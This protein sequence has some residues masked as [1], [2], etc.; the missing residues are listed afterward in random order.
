MRV[1]GALGGGGQAEP[2]RGDRADRPPGRRSGRAGGGTRR[3]R[4]G[5]T[6][7]PAGPCSGRP[8]RRSSPSAAGC[9]SS[10]RRAGRPR[11]RSSGVSSSY[12]WFIRSIVGV[13]TRVGRSAC[14]MA[15]LAR[16]VLPVPVGRTTTPRP[17]AFHQAF[18]PFGLVRERLLGDPDR[19][20]RRLRLVGAGVVD[21]GDLP[22]AKVLHDRPVPDRLGAVQAG[23][24][25]ELDARQAAVVALRQ[26]L[27]E[28]RPLVEDEPQ[29][30][31]G[32]R[33]RSE[34]PA[35]SSRPRSRTESITLYP[36]LSCPGEDH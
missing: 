23:P 2:E 24:R 9:R 33:S 22:V 25:V 27:D 13:M 15:R 19:P 14:S 3:R 20:V 1:V 4:S 34:R 5:R 30:R 36:S 18:E 6:C 16:C 32:R 35:V 17:P 8:S 12:H 10:R 7:C 26:A 28:D 11:W 21:V 31:A 29:C